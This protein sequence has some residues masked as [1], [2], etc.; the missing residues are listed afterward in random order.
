M[1]ELTS[2]LINNLW[3]ILSREIPS[4]EQITARRFPSDVKSEIYC[5]L[6]SSQ[7][8]HLLI[9]LGDGE[10]ELEDRGS[11]GI[12]VSTRGLV[13]GK[14][15]EVKQYIDIQCRHSGGHRIFDLLIA[16]ISD[17]LTSETSSVSEAT[18]SVLD[19][20]RRFWEKIPVQ[21]LT[22]N[23]Q[24]G[25]FS[26]LWFLSK[27]LIPAVGVENAVDYWQG[28]F[29]GKDFRVTD[30]SVEVKSSSADGGHIYSVNTIDQLDK[31]TETNLYLFGLL[32]NKVLGGKECL[33]NEVDKIR[34]LL[35]G[36]PAQSDHF[37]EGLLLTGYSD[38]HAEEYK[39]LC[40]EIREECLFEVRDNFP[41][42]SR[43]RIEIPSG[44]DQI[45]YT[46]NLNSF[47]HLI[48]AKS[49]SGWSF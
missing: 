41:R 24:T 32:L 22:R 42:L 34:N 25:L 49:P 3:D 27:W 15:D 48:V 38:F 18:L 39:K 2:N 14:S 6:D 35:S 45:Q 31:D 36:L 37:E 20:W 44:I 21:T 43:E 23:E 7:K 47:G 11:R 5:A 9:L 19:K 33:V 46:I 8:R 12:S 10:Q 29:G 26:E 4:G 40:F 13:L 1:A 17:A 16:D 30:F 28:P